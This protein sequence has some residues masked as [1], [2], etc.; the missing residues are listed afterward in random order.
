MTIQ[1]RAVPRDAMLFNLLSAAGRVRERID[2]AIERGGDVEMEAVHESFSASLTASE[3]VE[4]AQLL[5]RI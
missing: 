4:L 5:A 1:E 3:R 2:Q